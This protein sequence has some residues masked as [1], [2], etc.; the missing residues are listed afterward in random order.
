MSCSLA[1]ER[2]VFQGTC[3]KVGVRYPFSVTTKEKEIYSQGMALEGYFEVLAFWNAKN[4]TNPARAVKILKLI[5]QFEGINCVVTF[6]KSTARP[7][8]SGPR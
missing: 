4:L 5:K 7:P 6:Q 8:N 2:G 3:W 1:L